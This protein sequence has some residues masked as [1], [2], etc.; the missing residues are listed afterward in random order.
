MELCGSICYLNPGF[1]IPKKYIH[2]KYTD[3]MKSCN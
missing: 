3:T 1:S 2:E